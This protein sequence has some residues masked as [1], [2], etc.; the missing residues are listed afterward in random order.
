MP[1]MNDFNELAN[2]NLSPVDA[3]GTCPNLELPVAPDRCF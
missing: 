3:I 1:W 2:R